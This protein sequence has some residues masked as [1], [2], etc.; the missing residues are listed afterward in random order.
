MIRI[1]FYSCKGISRGGSLLP[2]CGT[3]GRSPADAVRL[4]MYVADSHIMPTIA[5]NL[6][7]IAFYGLRQCAYI[8]GMKK[9]NFRRFLCNCGPCP[10]F[11]LTMCKKYA[12]TWTP[13]CPM[14]IIFIC[15]LGCCWMRFQKEKPA[16]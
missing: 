11:N 4:Y 3:C 6:R 7:D 9:C 12:L 10:D 13:A 16:L 5:A 15:D 8:T 2:T 1:A 14:W